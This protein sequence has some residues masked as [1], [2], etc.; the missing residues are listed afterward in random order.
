MEKKSCY[1][2][3]NNINDYLDKEFIGYS[4]K[5]D[6]RGP[7]LINGSFTLPEIGTNP[8]VAEANLYAKD[9]SVSISIEHIDGQYLIGI[10]NWKE[11]EADKSVVL[12]E[13][14]YLT[15]RLTELQGAENFGKLKFM[16]AWI[17]VK[18]PLC[19]NMEV[20]EPAWRAFKGFVKVIN[21][22]PET[23]QS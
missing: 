23:L 16:R 22:N 3:T 1:L 15:H 17:P 21:L 18:D 10:V 7:E 9:G 11:I 13:Q 2:L 19:E 5:S 6:N 8:Y 4:W 12:E 14:T 20:L